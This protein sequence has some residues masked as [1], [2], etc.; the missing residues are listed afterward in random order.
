MKGTSHVYSPQELAFIEYRQAMSRRA[1]HAAFVA[2]FGRHEVSVDSLKQLCLRKGWGT[3]RT[4]RFLKGAVSL[5]KGKRCAPGKGGRHPNARK[6][7]FRK[8]RLPRNHR[9]PGHERID[10]KD[11]Y[12][13]LIV[14]ETNPWTGAKTRPM[15]KHRW[16]WQKLHGPV[17][18]GMALKCRDG[19][20]TNCD[21]S[22]WELIPRALLPRLNGRFGRDYDQAP[23]ALKPI[24]MAV[25][26]LEHAAR[27][28][29]M[30]SR[31]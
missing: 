22:N 3:G 19:D 7:Q 2:A 16:L 21:P 5:N 29:A 9:G 6:T 24:I 15:H 12:V 26:K 28:S 17:P 10:G 8:G 20:K 11:G 25:A 30:G 14:E 23:A 4:G 27:T 31:T 1:L 18:D 13:I